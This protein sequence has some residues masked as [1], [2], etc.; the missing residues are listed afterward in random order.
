MRASLSS[1][2]HGRYPYALSFDDDDEYDDEA[3]VWERFSEPGARHTGTPPVQSI[4]A[5]LV[6]KIARSVVRPV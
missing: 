5:V 3:A 1:V 4:S 2:E 6:V